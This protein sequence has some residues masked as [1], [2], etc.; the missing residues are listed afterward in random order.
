MGCWVECSTFMMS[1][2]DAN[3]CVNQK[4]L[5]AA[6][7]FYTRATSGR[8]F[9][10]FFTSHV[11][12]LALSAR[13]FVMFSVLLCHERHDMWCIAYVYCFMR[14][15]GVLFVAIHGNVTKLCAFLMLHSFSFPIAS[16]RRAIC[17]RVS[18]K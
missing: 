16:H 17:N 9:T 13:P 12:L 8:A 10:N 3:G 5:L 11:R 4:A 1:N 2:K 15:P 14:V 6:K 18:A 7:A